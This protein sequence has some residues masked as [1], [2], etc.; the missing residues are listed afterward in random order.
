M[1]FPISYAGFFAKS[2]IMFFLLSSFRFCLP[3]KNDGTS[4]LR[5]AMTFWPVYAG[6]P[7]SPRRLGTSLRVRG[8]LTLRKKAVKFYK[9]IN[10]SNEYTKNRI[11]NVSCPRLSGSK[12]TTFRG[13]KRRC[14]SKW[15]ALPWLKC[16]RSWRKG[17]VGADTKKG[18]LQNGSKY[19]PVILERS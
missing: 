2:H 12:R 7:L 17:Q 19:L 10:W 8:K 3:L 5:F 4:E 15:D 11:G 16:Q 6:L 9:S 13:A 18:F 1:Y 14:K